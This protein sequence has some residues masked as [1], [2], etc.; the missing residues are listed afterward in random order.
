MRMRFD[1]K[2]TKKWT[3]DLQIT[4]PNWT[5]VNLE[6][7]VVQCAAPVQQILMPVCVCVDNTMVNDSSHNK[8]R[9]LMTCTWFM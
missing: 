9:Q 6:P 5:V 7:Y 2:A 4:N 1:G 3:T 8:L